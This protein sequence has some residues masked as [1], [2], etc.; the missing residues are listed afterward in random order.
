MNKENERILRRYYQYLKLEKNFSENTIEAYERDLDKFLHF[1]DDEG[2]DMLH[3]ELNDFHTFASIMH[4]IGIS[5]T[6][7]SRIL[8][9]L[10]SFY[11]FL[12]ISDIIDTNPTELL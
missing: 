5:S 4:D 2:K 11:H 10:R 8:S 3:P 9:G 1:L 6:S 7:L 12:V